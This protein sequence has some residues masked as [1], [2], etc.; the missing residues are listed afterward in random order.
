LIVRY[1]LGQPDANLEDPALIP[2]GSTRTTGAAIRAHLDTLLP[3][4]GQGEFVQTGDALLFVGKSQEVES[5]LPTTNRSDNAE[6]N[7]EVHDSALMQFDWNISSPLL[8]WGFDAVKVAADTALASD[9]SESDAGQWDLALQDLLP[10][11]RTQ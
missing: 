10:P 11:I 7:I 5:G 3:L 9:S 4:S 8:P 6:P 1:L 2:A